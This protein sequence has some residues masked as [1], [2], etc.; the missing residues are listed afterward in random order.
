VL[1]APDA[2]NKEVDENQETPD[3]VASLLLTNKTICRNTARQYQ[4]S[5]LKINSR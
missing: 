2:E 1:E 4:T 3:N 5:S